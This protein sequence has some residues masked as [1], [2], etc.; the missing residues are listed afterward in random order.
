MP[1]RDAG[2]LGD[3][4]LVRGT[5]VMLAVGLLLAGCAVAAFVAWCCLR[6]GARSEEP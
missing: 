3:V 6:V 2:W 4:L 5:A 1:Q